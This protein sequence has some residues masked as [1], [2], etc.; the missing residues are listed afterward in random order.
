M[1][2]GSNNISSMHYGAWCLVEAP[3][4][5]PST[6]QDVQCE[7]ARLGAVIEDAFY[8]TVTLVI[9]G[10]LIRQMP[11]K[12]GREAH[13]TSPLHPGSDAYV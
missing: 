8:G 9:I 4:C 7:M 2:N 11:S 10:G 6:L 1:V 13:I 5:V 12:A 3:E